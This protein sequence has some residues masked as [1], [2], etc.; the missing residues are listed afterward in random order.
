MATHSSL[1]D[2]TT[3]SKK[4]EVDKEKE[5]EVHK[6]KALSDIPEPAIA[7]EKKKEA[8]LEYQ[9]GRRKLL[10]PQKRRGDANHDA[11]PSHKRW[12]S[13]RRRRPPR[14]KASRASK[15][16]RH[17]GYASIESRPSSSA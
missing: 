14:S 12:R 5:K 11:K 3:K 15:R 13:R 7:E 10:A 6:E 1:G 2:R 17:T 9:A 8:S 16:S 4:E